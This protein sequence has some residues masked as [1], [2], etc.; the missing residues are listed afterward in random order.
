MSKNDINSNDEVKEDLS[1]KVRNLEELVKNLSNQVQTLIT[2]IQLMRDKPNEQT[3]DDTEHYESFVENNYKTNESFVLPQTPVSQ[4]TQPISYTRNSVGCYDIVRRVKL[5]FEFG[6][7]EYD[8][9]KDKKSKLK[10]PSLAFQGTVLSKDDRAYLRQVT[11]L[12][13][14]FINLKNIVK[15]NNLSENSA[16]L[17][18]YYNL[19]EP[20]QAVANDADNLRELLTRLVNT[21]A[22]EARWDMYYSSVLKSKQ[23][24]DESASSFIRRVRDHM[25]IMGYGAERLI[26]QVVKKGLNNEWA[27]RNYLPLLHIQVADEKPDFSLEAT[28][29]FLAAKQDGPAIVKSSS[30]PKCATCHKNHKGPCRYSSTRRKERNP[31]TMSDVTC[32]SCNKKGH[33]ANRCPLRRSGRGDK[34]NINKISTSDN[35]IKRNQRA[36]LHKSVPPGWRVS[37]AMYG[38][39]GNEVIMECD[40]GC[41]YNV[42]SEQTAQ[43]ISLIKKEKPEFPVFISASKQPLQPLYQATWPVI[44]GNKVKDLQLI[45]VKHLAEPVLAVP[46]FADSVEEECPVLT[47]TKK[48]ITIQGVDFIASKDGVY[49]QKSLPKLFDAH[50]EKPDDTTQ[51]SDIFLPK[52]ETKFKL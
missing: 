44:W 3:Y 39:D 15:R 11:H 35:T 21:Y 19:G 51:E 37:L 25:T 6:D 46:P 4:R 23:K 27:K 50:R 1:E 28:L 22:P 2:G 47:Y 31:H 36:T 10:D 49:R 29:A 52:A 30:H 17:M 32:Y 40:T 43:H 33:K 18:L 26:I 14:V 38:K 45:V 7:M 13:K 24:V 48:K 9:V 20:A 41:Q 5:K 34:A 12:M 16:F 42:I 8:M